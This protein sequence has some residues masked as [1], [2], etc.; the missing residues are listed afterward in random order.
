MRI[1]SLTL[2]PLLILVS[3]AACGGSNPGVITDYDPEASFEGYRTFDLLPEGSGLEEDRIDIEEVEGFITTAIEA[4]L[5]DMGFT[6]VTD[7]SA[8][9]K[10]GYHLAVDAALSVNT[11][12]TGYQ[13]GGGWGWNNWGIGGGPSLAGRS[14]RGGNVEYR[15]YYDEG[16]IVLDVMD[17]SSEQL[18]WRSARHGR[19][20]MNATTAERR[21]RVDHI[22]RQLLSEFPPD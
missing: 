15:E 18:V 19:I 11:M 14:G 16:M 17:H 12:N 21:H 6:R 7:G 20:E 13:Y 9:F 10:V 4:T 1:A 22:V 2:L 3:L 5:V 8:D